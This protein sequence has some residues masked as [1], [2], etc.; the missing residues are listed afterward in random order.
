MRA[1]GLR[2]GRCAWFEAG[3]GA[4][5]RQPSHFLLLRQK[6]VTKEKAT[7]LAAT[8]RFATGNLRCSLFAGSAQTRFAQTRA[9]LIREKL[10]SSARPEG[11]WN[12]TRH[13]ASFCGL[14]FGVSSWS[15]LTLTHTHRHTH[16]HR[17]TPMPMPVPVPVPVLTFDPLSVPLSQASRSE[18]VGGRA[19]QW[20]VPL[21]SARAEERSFR[22][23]KGRACLSEASLRGPRLK[24]APQVARS[25]AEGRAQWGRL[26]FGYFLLAKQKKV[27][28]L[29]GRRPGSSLTP[30]AASQSKAQCPPLNPLPEGDE[31]GEGEGA[32]P[33]PQVA[34]REITQ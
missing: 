21:P 34:A 12:P 19:K 28:R 18:A 20:P 32:R 6:K 23:I 13:G 27:T 5:S 33:T 2:L 8:L 10:R 25:E 26:F 15:L 4:S 16:A 30:T 7:P 14:Q 1:P 9:A 24:R 22:R 11:T 3:A 31:E 29:P 17:R